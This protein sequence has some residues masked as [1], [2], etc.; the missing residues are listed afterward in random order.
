MQHSE[1]IVAFSLNTRAKDTREND[2]FTGE[3]LFPLIGSY[4]FAIPNKTVF[5]ALG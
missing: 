1:Y 5:E 3:T 2:T 4:S